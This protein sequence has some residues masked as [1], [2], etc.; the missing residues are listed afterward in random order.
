MDG[1]QYGTWGES[2]PEIGQLTLVWVSS[3][4][5]VELQYLELSPPRSKAGAGPR[6]PNLSGTSR[7]SSRCTSPSLTRWS[8]TIDCSCSNYQKFGRIS[9]KFRNFSA[10]FAVSA[11]GGH[12]FWQFL[13][14][15]R[16]SW[17]FRENISKFSSITANVEQ[18]F[19]T[20]SK[21]SAKIQ[22]KL[23]KI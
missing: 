5:P 8:T 10:D 17:K 9:G 6:P 14:S 3:S 16:K 13:T 1:P 7:G 12:G 4:P 2:V 11:P 20:M 22:R 18:F 19:Q 21:K 15:G 23:A